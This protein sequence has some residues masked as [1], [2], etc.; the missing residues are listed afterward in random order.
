MYERVAFFVD[1]L[2]KTRVFF[3]G[4]LALVAC[5]YVFWFLV[6]SINAA[7]RAPAPAGM[8]AESNSGNAITDGTAVAAYRLGQSLDVIGYASSNGLRTV[9]TTTARATSAMIS[10]SAESVGL[11]ARGVG[12]GIMTVGS[13]AGK[14]FIAA[15]KGVGFVLSAPFRF[16]GSLSGTSAVSAVIRPADHQ[17]DYNPVPVI[18]PNSPELLAAKQA[19]PAT[20]ASSQT[21]QAAPPASALALWPIHGMV[22]TQFGVPELPYQ[23]IHTGL[24][25]SDGKRSGI[26]PIK[27]FRQGTVVQT[28]ST[29]GLGNHVVVDHGNGVTSVYGHLASI[30]VQVGQQVDTTTTL[31]FEG[32]TGVSTGPHLHF[33]IRVNGQATDPHQFISGQP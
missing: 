31:G 12:G 33:E 17:P 22:T 28:L 2:A 18:D 15:G 8:A 23:A 26:T 21:A 19:L 3:A 16:I 1:K 27:A 13:A 9:S 32:T 24:D 10:A 14:G 25:I 11:A 30:A 7:S 29:G 5:F 6:A 4:V 20:A